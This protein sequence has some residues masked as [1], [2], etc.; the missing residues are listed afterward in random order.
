MPVHPHRDALQMHGSVASAIQRGI[1]EEA[2]DSML[3]IMARTMSEM[4]SSWGPE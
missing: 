3:G 1:P 4:R 2:R